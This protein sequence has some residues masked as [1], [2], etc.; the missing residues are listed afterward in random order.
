[1]S[2]VCIK[3]KKSIDLANLNVEVACP[4]CSGKILLKEAAPVVKKHKAR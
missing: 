3:C 1:M 2:Y 4:S